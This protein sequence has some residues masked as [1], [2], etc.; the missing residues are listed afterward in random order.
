VVDIV[1]LNQISPVLAEA[2]VGAIKEWHFPA[3]K[4]GTVRPNSSVANAK[5]DAGIKNCDF[6]A[7]S[8][9]LHVLQDSWAHQGKPYIAGVGHGRGAEWV[10]DWGW[11]RTWYGWGWDYGPVGGHWKRTD[12]TVGAATSGSADDVG[13]WPDDARDTGMATFKALKRFKDACPCHC[14]GP[15]GSKVKTSSGDAKTEK[16]VSDWLLDRYKGNNWVN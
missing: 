5:V 2:K 14:P 1:A 11:F 12:G 15:N 4:D 7:F 6:T 3:D 8:E 9:G 10:R 13:L 16:E